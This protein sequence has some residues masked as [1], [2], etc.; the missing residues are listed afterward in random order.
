M[1]VVAG[2]VG[3][4]GAGLLAAEAALRAGP[5]LSPWPRPRLVAPALA[6]CPELMVRGV[7]HRRD[8]APL[9]ARAD[10]VLLGPGLG[11]D[12]WG[13]Q[14][15]GAVLEARLP[16]VFDAD[17]LTLL[18][19]RGPRALPFPALLTL[20]LGRRGAF[21]AAPPR[22]WSPIASPRPRPSPRAMVCPPYLRALGRSL[23]ATTP[24]SAVASTGGNSAMATAP[25]SCL[26]A[27][28][29]PLQR[30]VLAGR[31]R[32]TLALGGLSPGAHGGAGGGGGA[33]R[34]GA[35]ARGSRGSGRGAPGAVP[36]G[37]RSFDELGPLLKAWAQ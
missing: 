20:I 37:A 14:L 12:G 36:P 1:L 30:P 2:G 4:G 17:G 32:R 28:D 24:A 21:L 26:P 31:M 6:R 7:T 25:G 22:R 34:G 29:G 9:L 3:M 23:P 8:L 27:R 11:L 19:E 10:A 16:T 15:F 18:A 33:H 13:R 5:A 35:V